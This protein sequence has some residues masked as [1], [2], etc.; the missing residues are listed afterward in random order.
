MEES[1]VECLP[2]IAPKN[3]GRSLVKTLSQPIRVNQFHP[4]A[5]CSPAYGPAD[6]P[7]KMLHQTRKRVEE[8]VKLSDLTHRL[9][10]LT[11]VL[12]VFAVIRYANMILDYFDHS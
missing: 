11:I 3:P 1:N 12:G 9:F 5:P 6:S 10:W 4:S 8:T 2:E 7:D